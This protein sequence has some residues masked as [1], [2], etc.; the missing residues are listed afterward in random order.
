MATRKKWFRLLNVLGRKCVRQVSKDVPL[1]A[2]T[3]VTAEGTRSLVEAG[4][5]IVKIGIGAGAMCT[6]RVMTGVG[7][8]QI[9]TIIECSAEAKRLGASVWADAGIRYPRDVALSIAAGADNLM[10]GS[11]W[12][13]TY[14]SPGDVLKDSNGRLYKE[15]FGMASRRAVLGRIKDDSIFEQRKKEF[16]EE[17]ISSNEYFLNPE[18]PAAEDI[19]DYITAGLRSAMA[20]SGARNIKEFQE[21]A[22]IGIQSTAGYQEGLP[23]NSSW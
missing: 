15:H 4:A 19:I 18:R 10:W 12:A 21:K 6:T 14:E 1:M 5:N 16:F 7:R 20:Y 2:G 17:G 13:G 3:V 22:I 11:M 23:L 9:S 8:P